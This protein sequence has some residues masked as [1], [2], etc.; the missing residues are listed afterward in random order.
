MTIPSN[1]GSHLTMYRVG[2]LTP[3]IGA[4]RSHE[5]LREMF[6]F[7]V[8]IKFWGGP[9][10]IEKEIQRYTPPLHVCIH[11]LHTD[12]VFQVMQYRACSKIILHYTY[13]EGR[14]RGH[15]GQNS[16]PSGIA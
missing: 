2:G 12:N 7:I 8:S 11:W 14:R 13:T 10:P 4:G 3:S 6:V 5:K 1:C 15:R 9:G 16:N